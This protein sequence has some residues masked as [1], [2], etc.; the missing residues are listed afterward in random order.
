LLHLR[1]FFFFFAVLDSELNID[2]LD[3]YVK[4]MPELHPK[5]EGPYPTCFCGDTCKMEVSV[6]IRRHARDSGCVR[7]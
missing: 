2:M 1:L 5:P 4:A 6:T 7:T 3:G